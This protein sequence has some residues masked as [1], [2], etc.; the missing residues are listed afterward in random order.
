MQEVKDPLGSVEVAQGVLTE[1][2]QTG[3]WRERVSSQILG[4]QGEEHLT[5]VGR[6]QQA[7]KPIQ[8][9]SEIVPVLRCG[10]CGMEGH[11][12]S[13][14]TDRFRPLLLQNAC[15]VSSAA[16]TASGAVG[17]QPAPHRPPS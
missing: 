7:R 14:R 13:Q 3:S 6:S 10:G 9:G 16:A 1:V 2:A 4:G 5:A 15:W 8:S 12:Y 11:P 17:R